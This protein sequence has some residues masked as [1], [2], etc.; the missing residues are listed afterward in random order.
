MNIHNELI[1][2]QDNLKV[3]EKDD[4]RADALVLFEQYL[5]KICAIGPYNLDD[6]P[7]SWT[8]TVWA[9]AS[10]VPDSYSNLYI[11]RIDNLIKQKPECSEQLEFLKV[12]LMWNR[13]GVHEFAQEYVKNLVHK[14]PFNV[15]FKHS[16]GHTLVADKSNLDLV[17]EGIDQY[18]KCLSLWGNIYGELVKVVVNLGIRLSQTRANKGQYDEALELLDKLLKI[19]VVTLDSNFNNILVMH[20]DYVRSS[21]LLEQRLDG[22]EKRI[23]FDFDERLSNE[24]KKTFELLGLF[25]AI[26]SFILSTVSLIGVINYEYLLPV[27]LSL[28]F[29]LVMFVLTISLSVNPRLNLKT[30][31][32]IYLLFIFLV[33]SISMPLIYKN[34]TYIVTQILG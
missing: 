9:Y 26:I 4:K 34:S 27:L 32:R 21:K 1:Q 22:M 15:E 10:N 28:G 12:E 24:R 7:L 6:W 33:V 16:Y 20:K 17:E 5:N 31:F 8:K 19:E 11:H 13:H 23:S 30:D 3:L 18:L 2:I 29:I 25:T 14:Y